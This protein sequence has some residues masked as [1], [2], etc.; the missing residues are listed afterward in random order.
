MSESEREENRKKWKE[1][2]NYGARRLVE[3]VISIFKRK[4]GDSVRAKKIE[5][6]RQEI[7]LKIRAYNH[8]G[9][10]WQDIA[11]LEHGIDKLEK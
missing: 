8:V 1:A 10:R 7:R 5:C 2:V 6:V 4:Y 3:I 11:K 9:G